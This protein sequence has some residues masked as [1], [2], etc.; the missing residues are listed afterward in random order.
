MQAACQVNGVCACV[1]C[2]LCIRGPDVL[3]MHSEQHLTASTHLL[4]TCTCCTAAN[5][6]VR[7]VS[8]LWHQKLPSEGK[9]G[10]QRQQP[11]AAETRHHHKQLYDDG[12]QL[13]YMKRTI[14]NDS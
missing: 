2:V 13:N 3:R 14:L 6:A 10:R 11:W 8:S 7:V 9:M 1:R 5:K 4:S 12:S